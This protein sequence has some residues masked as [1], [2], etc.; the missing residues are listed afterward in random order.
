[1]DS[2]P[3]L[4]ALLDVLVVAF[5][6]LFVLFV[7]DFVVRFVDNSEIDAN[8]LIVFNGNRGLSVV[9]LLNVNRARF[10]KVNAIVVLFGFPGEGK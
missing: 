9:G 1:M 6:V 8:N 5:K 2:F 3:I 7:E 4:P 10:A